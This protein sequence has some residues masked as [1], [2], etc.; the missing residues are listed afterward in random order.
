MNLTLMSVILA[1]EEAAHEGG[2]TNPYLFGAAALA[3]L[4]LLLFVTTRLNL[5][6]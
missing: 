4:L 3:V 1:S 5:D 6:R 2:H